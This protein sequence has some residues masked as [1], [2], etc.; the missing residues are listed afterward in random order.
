MLRKIRIIIAALV[1]AAALFLF[2]DHTGTAR[3]ALGW[4]AE[5]QFIPALLALN[6]VAVIAIAVVTLVFGRVYCS[7]VCP[8]GIMQ[9]LFSRIGGLRKKNRFGWKKPRVWVR[10]AFFAA[11]VVLFA[12]GLVSIASLIEPY[13]TFGRIVTAAMEGNAVTVA[14]AASFFI[15]IILFSFFG[16]RLWCN[17]VCPAGTVLGFISKYSLFRPVIDTEKCNGCTLCAR[18]CKCS[19][20]NPQ[21]HVVDTGRCVMCL[22]CLKN[23]RQ[24]AISLRFAGFGK[25]KA[26]S[27][28]TSDKAVDAS[29]RS[30]V[31]A[32]ALVT[33]AATLGAQQIKVDGGLAALEDKK[34]PEREVPL[35]PAGSVSLKH[36]TD[37]CIACQLC[38]SKCPSAVLRPSSK[39]ATLMQPELD[40]RMGWCRPSCNECSQV[41]PAGAIKPVTV[42]EKTSIAIG[43]AVWISEN[44]VVVTDGVTCG[45]CARHCPAGAIKMVS[46]GFGSDLKV[47][48][49]NAERCI[50]CGSCEYHCPARP[51]SAIYVKGNEV[52]SQK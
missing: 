11:F 26:V 29:R 2:S 27:A 18:N 37:K 34:A 4:L 49:V 43:R 15:V 7:V 32:A 25:K 30:F 51:V 48:S 52:H 16:G 41:C 36:F 14:V 10:I 20:I 45:N 3:Q 38:V 39:L 8:L 13:S 21:E 23:C 33:S 5:I 44:C 47:P 46:T 35:K 50:G 19:C 1:F 9:D 24:G 17:T 6:S 22:D 31:A 12:A 28:E 40:F 42:E